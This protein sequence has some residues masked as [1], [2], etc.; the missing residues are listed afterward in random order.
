V[1]P[2]RSNSSTYARFFLDYVTLIGCPKTSV[3]NY[4]PMPRNHPEEGTAA[5]S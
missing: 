4:Q 5:Y 2:W 1:Q 3:T